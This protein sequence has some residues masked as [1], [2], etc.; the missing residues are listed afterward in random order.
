MGWS[1]SAMVLVKLTVLGRLIDFGDNRTRAYCG[2]SECRVGVIWT[3]F[4]LVYRFS[5]FLLL[6][7]RWPD[8][9]G[10]TV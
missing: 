3:F 7:G 9:D 2:Y 6:S 4:S 10:N 1:G 5:F 8:I